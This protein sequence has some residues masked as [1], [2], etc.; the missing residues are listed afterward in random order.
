M[1]EADSY[2]TQQ[3]SI[4]LSECGGILPVAASGEIVS[5]S[6]PSSYPPNLNCIWQIRV[7]SGY[8]VSVTYVDTDIEP[9]SRCVKDYIELQN[10]VSSTSP[11]LHKYCARALPG[12][13]IYKSSG[14][15]MRVHFKT[16]GDGSGRGFKLTYNQSLA[17]WYFVNVGITDI[18]YAFVK[19]CFALKEKGVGYVLD[20][21]LIC[22]ISFSFGLWVLD[23]FSEFFI[24]FIGSTYV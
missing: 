1:L 23:M 17:G 16:D 8:Q 15:S 10:G 18:P 12:Q 2:I 7:P 11:S 20:R 13:I 6:Y 3:C 19:Q 4:F 9:S 21:L 5:P 24:F 14:N 22:F